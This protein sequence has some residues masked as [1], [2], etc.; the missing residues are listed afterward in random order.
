M[1]RARPLLAA[2]NI[3]EPAEI[4]AANPATEVVAERSRI[5]FDR[6]YVSMGSRPDG[7]GPDQIRFELDAESIP[8]P[9]ANGCSESF[10]QNFGLKLSIR[11]ERAGSTRLLHEDKTIPASRNCP[12]GYDISAV[13][14]QP[15]FPVTDR[16]V[17]IVG[18]YSVGFEG[19]NH[20][21]IAIPFSISD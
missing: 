14:A 4:L 15:G 18:V 5:A 12:L 16:M 13:A 3:T 8:L 11:D 17:A 7:R 21:Y 2:S 19:A 20:R 6:W 9:S 10:G 1:A